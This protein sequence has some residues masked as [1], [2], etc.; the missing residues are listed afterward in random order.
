MES[1]KLGQNIVYDHTL[2]N[3]K[4]YFAG[5]LNL[6]YDNIEEIYINFKNKFNLG[7]FKKNIKNKVYIDID[8]ISDA[9][10]EYQLKYL[11]QYL[12][13][14]DYLEKINPKKEFIEESFNV[15]VKSIDNL[16]NFYTH[17][18]HKPIGFENN[19]FS[20]IDS[21]FLKVINNVK[22]HKM[23]DDKTR[24]LL[25]KNLSENLS[26]L[27]HLK[28]EELKEKKKK[29]NKI[30]LDEEQIKNNVLNSAFS[31]LLYHEVE[32]NKKESVNRHYKSELV[33]PT[34]EN[35]ITI[36]Q[37]GLLFLLGIF[38]TKKQ[39]EDLR[40][41]VKGFKAKFIKEGDSYNNLKS[42]ATHWVFSHLAL[43]ENKQKLF[44]QFNKE[45]L[46]L[47]IIDELS[48][49]PHEVYKTLD[50]EKQNSFVED[51]N[52][53]LKT[54]NEDLSLEESKVV[55][56]VIRKRYEDKFNYFVLRYLDEFANFPT[57]RFQIHLGNYL[58][59]KRQKN[60]DGTTFTT[61][62]IVKEKI[63]VFGKLSEV[64]QLKTNYFLK[65]ENNKN[66]QD[67]E[68]FPNP[69]Y[70]FV[71]NNIPIYINLQKSD[72]PNSRKLF[73]Q[74]TSQKINRKKEETETY[75]KR[76]ANKLSKSDITKNIENNS[77]NE[78][79][80]IILREP[81]ALL[82]LNELPALL[83]DLLVN[84]KTKENVE[85]EKDIPKYI[86]NK[87]VEKLINHFE[88]I[89]NY[90]TT[91]KLSNSQISR[92][93]KKSNNEQSIDT[94]KLVKAI[95]N[96]LEIT[97]QKITLIDNHREELR[98]TKNKRKYL[99]TTKELGNE[100]TWLAYDLKRFMPKENRKNLKGY[101][102]SQLQYSLSKFNDNQKEAY[103]LLK[104]IWDFDNSK[105]QWNTWIKDLL[106]KA[107]T[108][109]YFY[110]NYLNERKNLLSG[111]YEN[112]S[113]FTNNKKL[114]KKSIQ[115]H[116][117][118]TFF[119][120][121]LYKLDTT[122]NQIN[123]LL[124]SPL[125]FP[126]G[127]FDEKPTFIKD[128]KVSDNPEL[129]A[130]WFRYSYDDKHE[131]Q[132]FYNLERDYKELFE[133]Q[134]EINK[135]IID[136]KKE[137]TNDE[138]FALLK[139]K[140]D[141]KI[142]KVKTNDLFLKLMVDDIHQKL[143]GHKPNISLADFYLSQEERIKKDKEAIAQSKREIGDKTENIINDK[144]IWSKTI[145]YKTEHIDEPNIKLKDIGKFKHF[146]QSEK[147]KT[148]FEYK[149]ERKWTKQ[150]LD[151]EL[152]IKPTSYEVIRREIILKEIQQFEK[153]IL[154]KNNFNQEDFD[155]KNHPTELENIGKKED[156]RH[157]NFRKYIINGLLKKYNLI[158]EE[159]YKWLEKVT[160]ESITLRELLEK[161]EITRNAFFIFYIR[162]KFAHNQL[163]KKEFM[164][165]FI[166]ETKWDEKRS[167]SQCILDY[168]LM[169]KNKL[170]KEI[171]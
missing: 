83:Y 85:N 62:R 127:I 51:I 81:T 147:V 39:S 118:W 136:N 143:F 27:F 45:S 79:N 159:E 40:S 123:K 142:K 100:A 139:M 70:N 30:S 157:P 71:G 99:F 128:K 104:E 94:N 75:K 121:R 89:K 63:N 4:H 19:T 103:N 77:E 162:N 67:L 167:Y 149:L 9:D 57:L 105:Y 53:Y 106:T 59:D 107:R 7:I 12:P 14:L 56:P 161:T 111:L 49:V 138:Q 11:K 110:T 32:K 133:K 170:E 116:K 68:I 17:Y 80:R 125:V 146:L 115:Q 165:Y 119:N 5:F 3:D 158:N 47:Q 153:F 124:T 25:N 126:R 36:S 55:H 154:A 22:Q 166:K 113:S 73:G 108:F 60:I 76:N 90:D 130:E 95:K 38:L 148:I 84:E 87:I 114:L 164:D 50:K 23:K 93:L 52:E 65:E 145:P 41:R 135:G 42:M 20:L 102:F 152:L 150:E 78:N 72:V 24:H 163:V 74:I 171:G 92:K 34:T 155:K 15:L 97:E 169:V 66:E 156:D 54:G 98:H 109:E 132:T 21:L 120:E 44:S 117:L 82:S 18:Y 61:E 35:G 46:L 1:E 168:F 26:K 13:V 8:T 37:S 69:S 10:Y 129:F 112:I 48:K 2:F 96:E 141:L 58:H 88:T 16:R 140:Q 144:F 31:H 33:N 137:L 29:N 101:Q 134:K 28:K 6:A 86:E 43:R 91:Q 64:S 131:F 160:V 151:D 122:Q